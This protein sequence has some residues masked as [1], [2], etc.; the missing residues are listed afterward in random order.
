MQTAAEIKQAGGEAIVVPGDV[1]AEDFP[2][3]IVKETVKQFGGIDIIIN[4]AGRGSYFQ[5][6]G[7]DS[8]IGVIH[9]VNETPCDAGFTWDGV[10]HK[11]TPK[12]WDAMLAVHC[13]APFRLIQVPG[14][15]TS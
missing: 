10:I 3:R 13:T 4:N 1:T 15:T 6:L 11:I 9:L 2:G 8:N 12:Q 14:L 5:V 7:L